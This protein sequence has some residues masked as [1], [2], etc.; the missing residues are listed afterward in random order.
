[1]CIF[2]ELVST[3]SYC[4][5]ESPHKF[6]NFCFALEPFANTFLWRSIQLGD[7]QS[8]RN[9]NC[10]TFIWNENEENKQS[11]SEGSSRVT[12]AQSHS[13]FSISSSWEAGA[14]R[15][16]FPPSTAG[17]P[18]SSWSS[19]Q[20]PCGVCHVVKI[21]QKLHKWCKCVQRGRG[22]LK[23][24]LFQPKCTKSGW[25]KINCDHYSAAA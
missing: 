4:K 21:L 12:P 16:E 5:Q 24:G 19:Q 10:T 3:P 8:E 13:R 2:L 18:V 1:M 9:C 20:P 17:F 25:N 7:G 15:G 14:E 6:C 23:M 11:N 22:S